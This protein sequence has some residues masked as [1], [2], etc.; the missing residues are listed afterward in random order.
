MRTIHRKRKT[1]KREPLV[2]ITLSGESTPEDP[3]EFYVTFCES[4]EAFCRPKHFKRVSFIFNFKLD[5]YNST[6]AFHLTRILTI[7]KP[8]VKRK[9]V[10]IKWFYSAD[11]EDMKEMGEDL[12]ETQRAKMKMIKV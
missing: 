7:L 5:Y 6:S 1:R 9:L 2:E 11:D 4:L 12:I 10:I 3:N 8:L